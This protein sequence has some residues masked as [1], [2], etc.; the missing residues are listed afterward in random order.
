MTVYRNPPREPAEQ[1]VAE[2]EI[3]RTDCCRGSSCRSGRRW[4]RPTMAGEEEE[5]QVTAAVCFRIPV[6]DPAHLPGRL[7]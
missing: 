6:F 1:V 3:D 4:L 5:A 2:H 7:G